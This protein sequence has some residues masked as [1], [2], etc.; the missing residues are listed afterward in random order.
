MQASGFEPQLAGRM[1]LTPSQSIFAS[2]EAITSQ[3]KTSAY[4]SCFCDPALL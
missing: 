1:L 4:P 3:M 2:L